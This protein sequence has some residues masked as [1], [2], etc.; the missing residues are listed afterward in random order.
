MLQKIKGNTWSQ[1]IRDG[2]KS[3]GDKIGMVCVAYLTVNLRTRNII[4][5][6]TQA[7]YCNHVEPSF[8][9]GGLGLCVHVNSPIQTKI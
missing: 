9:E 3:I 4:A 7:L 8:M 2:I 6:I 1:A 5:L